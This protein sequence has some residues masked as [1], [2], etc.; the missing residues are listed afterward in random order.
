M[1]KMK[2]ILSYLR[3]VYAHMYVNILPAPAFNPF[4]R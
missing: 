4:Y 3:S 2:L 1:K